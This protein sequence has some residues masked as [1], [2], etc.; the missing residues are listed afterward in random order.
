MLDRLIA[1]HGRRPG[2]REHPGTPAG[3]AGTGGAVA[4]VGPV[5]SAALRPSSCC[6][7][8]ASLRCGAS[9]AGLTTSRSAPACAWPTA[10]C[11]RSG[12]PRRPGHRRTSTRARRQAR[13]PGPG[14]RSAGR[15]PRRRRLATRPGGRSAAGARDL[16]RGPSRRRPPSAADGW[17]VGGVVEDWGDPGTTTSGTCG[18][19]RP[20][21]GLSSCAAA[22]TGSSPSRPATRSTGTWS[23]PGA[24]L[25]H[26]RQP[27][28][29]PVVGH[30][31]PGD[32]DHHAPECGA[33]GRSCSACRPTGDAVPAAPGDADGRTPRSRTPSSAR[34]T[35]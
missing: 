27:P 24:G 7:A 26:R 19:P 4:V 11:G 22:G 9:S 13:A 1:P 16:G 6:W 35:G 3:A 15:P 18:I 31:R 14:R 32:I 34:I 30:T 33:T 23:C 29:P 17:Y 10:P 28:R 8:A 2:A 12:H 25:G 21:C 5:G 20:S